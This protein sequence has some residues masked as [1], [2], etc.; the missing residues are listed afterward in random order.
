MAQLSEENSV[1][2]HREF[3]LVERCQT[4]EHQYQALLAKASHEETKGPPSKTNRPLPTTCTPRRDHHSHHHPPTTPV[5]PVPEETELDS[6]QIENEKLKKELECL[7]TNFQLMSQKS[8]LVKKEKKE[9]EQSLLDL[10]GEFDRVLSEKADMEIKFEET[11][12]ALGNKLGSASKDHRR[13]GELEKAAVSLSAQLEE[14]KSENRVLLSQLKAEEAR[15]AASEDLVRKLQEKSKTLK[16]EKARADEELGTLTSQF[17]ELEQELASYRQLK[18]SRAS[19]QRQESEAI[20]AY[21]TKLER[22]RG[23]RRGLEERLREANQSLEEEQ[24]RNTL[25]EQAN[26]AMKRQLSG[27]EAA[28]QQLQDEKQQ[29][30][31]LSAEISELRGQLEALSEENVALQKECKRFE[32]SQR[33]SQGQVQELVRTRKEQHRR[34][35]QQEETVRSLQDQIERQKAEMDST[36]TGMRESKAECARLVQQI[37]ELQLELANTKS[38]KLHF[39]TEVGNLVQKVEELEQ[40]NFELSSKLSDAH[41]ETALTLIARDEKEAKLDELQQK[42][43]DAKA[44]LL[45]KESQIAELRYS[46]ELLQ[47]ENAD[48]L[49]QVTSLSEMVAARNAKIES[50]QTEVAYYETNTRDIMSQIMQLE[51]DHGQCGQVK[52]GLQEEIDRVSRFQHEAERRAREIESQVTAL[53]SELKQLRD[54]SASL[55][56][57]NKELGQKLQAQAERAEGLVLSCQQQEARNRQLEQEVRE[58]ESLLTSAKDE[59]EFVTKSSS[60]AQNSLRAEVESLD[61]KCQELRAKCEDH[62]EVELNMRAEASQLQNEMGELQHVNAELEKDRQPLQER[63]DQLRAELTSVRDELYV[64]QKELKSTKSELRY[65]KRKRSE[66]ER[67]MEG[68]KGEGDEMMAQFELLREEMLKVLEEGGT[69]NTPSSSRRRIKGLLKQSKK[70]ILKPLHNLVD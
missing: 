40:W 22:V 44:L 7:L 56:S 47:S 65:Q 21:Q 39:E 37:G 29:T 69:E 59:L 52:R 33:Q 68:M 6:L 2:Q 58:K 64:A 19:L 13:E 28:H 25:L 38:T 55:E 10:Q 12:M 3:E 8:A 42:I 49:S 26:K 11:K 30:S 62:R 17:Q 5:R 70:R 27:L 14:V 60:D 51:E 16:A 66:T 54:Y 41:N 61:R 31:S 24:A 20:A 1:L 23:E 9:L 67:E 48:M 45:E 36:V 34:A 43:Q 46:Q 35:E 57:A 63:C 32:A 50:L 18:A 4:L 15:I 53:R